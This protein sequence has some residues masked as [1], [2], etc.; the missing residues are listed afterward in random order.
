MKRIL[1]AI[2]IALA[3]PL[4]AASQSPRKEVIGY[5]PSW[6]WNSAGGGYRVSALH[7]DKLTIINYAFFAPMP[8]GAIRGIDTAGDALYLRCGGDSDIVSLSHRKNVEVMLSVGGW[9]DSEN[10]PAVAASDQRRS[11]FAHACVEAIRRFGFDG[12]DIDW[13][14]P[15]LTDHN[16]T[17]ADTH[18]YTLLLRTLRDSLDGYGLAIGRHCLLSAAL[19][20]GLPFAANFEMREVAGLLDFLNIMTYDFT[21]SWDPLSYYNSP[22]HAP[23]GVDSTRCVAAAYQ[24]YHQTYNVPDGKINL[25]VPFYGHTFTHC[26]APQTSHAGEDTV[27]FSKRG[28]MYSDIVRVMPQCVRHWD[29]QAE[30]PYLVCAD[31][32]LFV[33][34]DDVES[35]HAKAAFV[36]DHHLRGL[37]I[38]EL[39]GDLMPDGSSPLLEAIATTFHSGGAYK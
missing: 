11:A 5:Y 32:N 13:E 16:G 7:F 21:G 17:P 23:A 1:L 12:I 38:W 39:T 6:K 31:W 20:A 34:Y 22:L 27:H 19:P 28:A 29:P 15:G 30:V 4:T 9:D 8:D 37:I 33:S 14:F 26:T 25:G 18:N 2:A 36:V 24:L 10:F 3:L 35:I